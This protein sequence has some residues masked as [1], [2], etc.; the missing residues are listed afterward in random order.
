ME[1]NGFLVGYFLWFGFGC[2]KSILSFFS[3]DC[4]LHVF[5]WLFVLIEGSVGFWISFLVCRLISKFV[6]VLVPFRSCHLKTLVFRGRF[7]D[8]HS[9]EA[10]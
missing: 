2:F 6:S 5:C 9:S 7:C 8:I 1:E 4:I 10:K 3:S